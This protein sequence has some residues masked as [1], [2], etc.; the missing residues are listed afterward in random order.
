[1]SNEPENFGDTLSGGIQDVSAL[2]PLLGTEQCERHV[3]S[4]LEKGYFYAA[5]S[6]L[7]LFG[8]LGSVK[9][10]F[11]TFVGTMTYSKFY[12]G[13]WLDDA[14]FGTA[15]S[16]SSMVTIDK[17]TG[18]Y[19]AEVKLRKLLEEQHI[20]DPHLVSGFEWP[21][22][23]RARGRYEPAEALKEWNGRS[24]EEGG[25][26]FSL[27]LQLR[28]HH[29]TTTS[30]QW[31]KF[32]HNNSDVFEEKYARKAQPLEQRIRE[33]LRQSNPPSSTE[34][35]RDRA[36]E[37][38]QAKL[39]EIL[40]VDPMLVTYQ[41]LIAVG[42]AMIV[43]GYI[44][45]FSLVKSSDAS[46]GPYVWFAMEAALSLV[47]IVLWGW[48]PSWDEETG[49]TMTLQ[50]HTSDDPYY[51]MIT[52]P[53]IREDLGFA[54]KVPSP[55]SFT[56]YNEGEFFAAATSWIGPL[57]RL[58]ANSITLYYALL[59]CQASEKQATSTAFKDL[60]ITILLTDS[61]A[62]TF[63]CHERD[64]ESIA[65]FSSKLEMLPGTGS[66]YQV[67]LAS[68]IKQEN[69]GFL[70][71]PLFHDVLEHAQHIR[72][73]LFQV[74]EKQST[75]SLTWNLSGTP[76]SQS[77][78]LEDR[79]SV[80]SALS[81]HDKKYIDL[82]K[83]WYSVSTFL[84]N[85]QHARVGLVPGITDA[86]GKRAPFIENEILTI[87]ECAIL[88]VY[89]W[90]RECTF[91]DGR[92]DLDKRLATQLRPECLREMHSRLAARKQEVTWR[93]QQYGRQ[94]PTQEPDS[95]FELL[96]LHL[97]KTWDHL[98]DALQALR[99]SVDADDLY[100]RVQEIRN[101]VAT[102]VAAPSPSMTM[103]QFTELL[104]KMIGTTLDSEAIWG[105]DEPRGER[106]SH[107][108]LL[109]ATFAGT[110]MPSNSWVPYIPVTQNNTASSFT[111]ACAQDDHDAC[112][113]ELDGVVVQKQYLQWASHR[114]QVISAQKPQL[115]TLILR[116]FDNGSEEHKAAVTE[117]VT[118]HPNILSLAGM[119]CHAPGDDCRRSYCRAVFAN[120][121][122]WKRNVRHG[123][124]FTYRVGFEASDSVDAQAR[125]DHIRLWDEGRCLVLF[126]NPTPGELVLTFLTRRRKKSIVLEAILKWDADADGFPCTQ[127]YKIPARE[128]KNE[129]QRVVFR[130]RTMAQGFGELAIQRLQRYEH[131][132]IHG[133]VELQWEKMD[134]TEDEEE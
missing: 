71:S 133:Q 56:V 90:E 43:A 68:Q 11:A 16:V 115:T 79:I 38:I 62:F 42:M 19:G 103:K 88:E 45:C 28:I 6:T 52:S 122:A 50:L 9:A 99:S 96:G 105:G 22:W 81:D 35:G 124:F 73:R 118:K 93:Y 101:T 20:D 95:H 130:F 51:P 31:M 85:Q 15:G 83:L 127:T 1:M 57:Q 53:H 44:G 77:G 87:I 78:D 25:K 114:Q 92:R 37:D 80:G 26:Q 120:R 24:W 2:L 12:G 70:R 69:D 32:K 117:H 58:G 13:R 91:V 4:S 55:R 18:L 129:L 100:R 7:S 72:S 109:L 63:V 112:A 126:F 134:E 64:A 74:G 29:I 86:S 49:L 3:G 47:R 119:E 67:T 97:K 128:A 66:Y 30:L 5:A 82:R 131:W 21:G 54:E 59:A 104:P 123:S 60:S 110:S 89:L 40:Y 121:R 94:D 106:L 116:H 113:L 23:R 76:S 98:E 41:L 48:N 33:Y 27:A 36:P 39:T 102:V 111:L 65:V 107:L 108:W 75:L 34:E 17:D 8:S 10:G 14:G 84:D 46:A 61:R 132:K 125:G